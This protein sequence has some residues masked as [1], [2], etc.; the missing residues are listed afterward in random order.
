MKKTFSGR[1]QRHAAAIHAVE[2]E[3]RGKQDQYS[4]NLANI[5]RFCLKSQTKLYSQKD[6]IKLSFFKYKQN[7]SYTK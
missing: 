4:S 1:V 3:V 2:I 6:Y 5:A 7:M